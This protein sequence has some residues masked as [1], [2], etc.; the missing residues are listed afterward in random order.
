MIS[1]TTTFLDLALRSIEAKSKRG[2][3]AWKAATP[4]LGV[5]FGTRFTDPAR[6]P[7]LTLRDP[8]RPRYL[9]EDSQQ[10]D[11]P[12]DRHVLMI[13]SFIHDADRVCLNVISAWDL[14]K[15]HC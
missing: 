7:R 14:R 13:R 6:S 2:S 1:Y 9:S 4:E 10:R 8:Y 5:L 12:L 11:W 3:H 15:T